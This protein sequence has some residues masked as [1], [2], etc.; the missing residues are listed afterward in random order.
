MQ[1][2]IVIN[3][4]RN[5]G[6]GRMGKDRPPLSVVLYRT[7]QFH[8]REVESEDYRTYIGNLRKIGCPENTIKDIILTDVMKLY[9]A[10]RGQFFHN[11][12]AFRFWETNERRALNARQLEEKERQLAQIDKELPPVL[13][14]LLGINYEREINKYFVDTQEDDRR[15]GFLD[16]TKHSRILA[17]REEI[18]TLRE[19][20][21]E[22]AGSQPTGPEEIAALKQIERQR[23]QRLGEILSQEELTEYELRTSE[24]AER[25]RAEL[26]GFNPTEEEFRSIYELRKALDDRFLFQGTAEEKKEAEHDLDEMIRARLGDRVA[27]YDR[28]KN[29]DFR[30]LVLFTETHELPSSTAAAIMEIKQI[31]EQERRSLFANRGVAEPERLAALRAIE[32]ET[33]KGVKDTLGE[34]LFRKY[35]QN[36]GSWVRHLSSPPSASLADIP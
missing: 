28:A 32:S 12:K 34:K 19:D 20:V 26:V 18:E 25:L 22:R 27:D 16:G 1:E 13:R 23:K 3:A 10:R 11:G 30:N 6:P 17:L 7:N 5:P 35:S 31:A 36:A 15:L 29:N 2:P 8:W 33:E 9:A 4:H 24:T 21:L 14:D